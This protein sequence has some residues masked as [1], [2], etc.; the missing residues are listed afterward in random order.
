MAD[1]RWGL[2]ATS[3][4]RH[5]IHINCDGLGTSIDMLCGAKLWILYSPADAYSP[6]IFGDIDQFFNGFDVTD[7][8]EYWSAEAVY[9]QPG[10]RL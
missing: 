3:D 5:W 4:A 2:A 10:T 6:D 9:L 7:P 1:M 8:P